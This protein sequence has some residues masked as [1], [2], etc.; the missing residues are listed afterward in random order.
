MRAGPDPLQQK[1]KAA[2]K[3]CIEH[4]HSNMDNVNAKINKLNMVTPTIQQQ[5]I[6]Y[7]QKHIH[8]EI[9]TVLNTYKMKAERGDLDTRKPTTE[10]LIRYTIPDPSQKTRL[11]DVW[12]DIK[13]LF[14]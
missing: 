5:M 3:T 9:D 11:R 8:N 1:A 14:S 2:W 6:P 10:R 7:C 4:F 13:A 12:S